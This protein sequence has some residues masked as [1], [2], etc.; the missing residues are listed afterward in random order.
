MRFNK[1]VRLI[2]CTSATLLVVGA[3]GA[4]ASTGGGAGTKKVSCP[5]DPVV[6]GFQSSITAAAGTANAGQVTETARDVADAAIKAVNKTCAAGVPLKLLFCDEKGDPNEALACAR[7]IVESDAVATWNDGVQDSANYSKVF[8]DAGIPEAFVNALGTPQIFGETAENVFGL[9]YP[10]VLVNGYASA[11]ASAGAK[12]LFAMTLDLPTVKTF[13]DLLKTGTEALGLKYSGQAFIPQD[14]TDMT[15][16]TAQALD[17]GTD[18]LAIIANHEPIV[19]SLEEAGKT[20]EDDIIVIVPSNS[21][22]KDNLKNMGDSGNGIYA[23]AGTA[24]ADKANPGTKQF[25]KEVKAAGK[26]L[27]AIGDIQMVQWSA[28][29][30][31]AEL[32]KSLGDAGTP[33]TRESVKTALGTWVVDEPYLPSIDYAKDYYPKGTAF[34]D[35]G[36]RLFGDTY[37]LDQIKNGKLVQV[38]KGFIGVGEK[39]KLKK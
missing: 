35:L 24:I 38:S 29:H 25:F 32:V 18:A 3:S 33:V 5:G 7:E 20:A 30:Q 39:A 15:S 11:A 28:V 22:N 13:A 16:Y 4:A 2:A 31:F 8:S 6:Y 37:A 21:V 14:A 12:S 23:I 26:K 10:P 27:D 17:S 1:I 36:L 34:G 19:K 9:Y